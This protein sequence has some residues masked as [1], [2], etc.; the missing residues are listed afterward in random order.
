MGQNARRQGAESEPTEF[1][2]YGIFLRTLDRRKQDGGPLAI[3]AG[4]RFTV[5]FVRRLLEAFATLLGKAVV[6]A[7]PY[8]GGL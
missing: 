7:A 1:L 5:D 2:A 8:L 6:T 4:C 3:P